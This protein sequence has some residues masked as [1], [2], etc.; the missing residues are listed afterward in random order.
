MSLSTR[1]A[2]ALNQLT[3]AL[4]ASAS[5]GLSPHCSDAD[6]WLWL[7]EHPADRT[8]NA[9]EYSADGIRP[10]HR[11][12]QHDQ[13]GGRPRASAA[14]LATA[15][16]SHLYV[17]VQSGYVGKGPRDFTIVVVAE[18]GSTPHVRGRKQGPWSAVS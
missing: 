17:G 18:E 1:E 10:E 8:S 13:Q 9:S 2:L 14:S 3:Q 5:K 11:A 15:D 6:S 4:I 7:S 16:V 12:R